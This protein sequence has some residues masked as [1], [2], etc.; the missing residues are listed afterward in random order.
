[1]FGGGS[2][3]GNKLVAVAPS[4][5]E[6][7][8]MFLQNFGRVFGGVPGANKDNGA[9][10]NEAFRQSLSGYYGGQDFNS[11]AQNIA[12]LNTF[13]GG[14]HPR[15]KWTTQKAGDDSGGLFGMIHPE[16]NLF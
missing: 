2:G 9:L 10:N 14:Q 6:R 8:D 11:I 7:R 3:G 16:F 12:R 5:A 4:A 1:M 13:Q 15:V